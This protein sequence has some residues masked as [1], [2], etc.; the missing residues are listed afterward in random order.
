MNCGS[1]Y[2][3]SRNLRQQRYMIAASC[4]NHVANCSVDAA[5][6]A[7]EPP[8]WPTPSAPF[9][10]DSLTSNRFVALATPRPRAHHTTPPPAPAAEAPRPPTPLNGADSSIR[11]CLL[12]PA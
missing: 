2:S 7:I 10:R 9:Y 3:E 5:H 11:A 4:G 12:P 6:E 8:S 1:K